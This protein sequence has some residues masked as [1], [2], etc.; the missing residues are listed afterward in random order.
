MS[1]L[2]KMTEK[3]LLGMTLAELGFDVSHGILKKG[4]ASVEPIDLGIELTPEVPEVNIT[5]LGLFMA[6]FGEYPLC[7]IGPD[8]DDDFYDDIPLT[9]FILTSNGRGRYYSEDLQGYFDECTITD[10]RWTAENLSGV[11]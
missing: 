8:E 11:E 5:N 9:Q 1:E 4:F 2:K 10:E 7:T 3:E 6:K